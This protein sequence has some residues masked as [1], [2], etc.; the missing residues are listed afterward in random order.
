MRFARHRIIHTGKKLSSDESSKEVLYL[1]LVSKQ[2]LF[3]FLIY[4]D[5]FKVLETAFK[6]QKYQQT[7]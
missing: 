6:T 2:Y 1:I 4:N 5:A 3:F 7:N